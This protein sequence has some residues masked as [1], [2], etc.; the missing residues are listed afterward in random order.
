MGNAPGLT[1][2]NAARRRQP[3]D[4]WRI[5]NR[6]AFPGPDLAR[7]PQP[8]P[9]VFR[10]EVLEQLASIPRQPY[11]LVA[12]ADVYAPGTF[13]KEPTVIGRDRLI[14]NHFDVMRTERHA[15][16]PPH[17]GLDQPTWAALACKAGMCPVGNDCVIHP[18]LA[19]IRTAKTHDSVAPL[20]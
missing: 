3:T 15:L 14:E 9:V 17:D 12:N 13:R 18:H 4:R 1:H 7:R 8:L 16:P 6:M 5:R 11:I 19:S 20:Q 2:H 10:E